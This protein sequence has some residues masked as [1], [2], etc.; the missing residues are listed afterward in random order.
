VSFTF[1]RCRISDES[2]AASLCAND[3]EWQE[4]Q[5]FDADLESRLAGPLCERCQE[6]TSTGLRLSAGE[7]V[8]DDCHEAEVSE[9]PDR[10]VGSTSLL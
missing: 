5:I 8:C 10:E 2:V 3:A 9:P 7:A 1:F 6:E 4:Q